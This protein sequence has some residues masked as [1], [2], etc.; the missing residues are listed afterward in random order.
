LVAGKIIDVPL[1][2]GGSGVTTS[3][4]RLATKTGASLNTGV[5]LSGTSTDGFPLLRE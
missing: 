2:I 5:T 1:S 4:W 3:D